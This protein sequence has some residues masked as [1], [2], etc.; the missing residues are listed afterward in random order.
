MAVEKYLNCGDAQLH[1]EVTLGFVYIRPPEY[2]ELYRYRLARSL[3][4]SKDKRTD[5][6][7]SSVGSSN[8]TLVWPS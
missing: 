1:H 8:A 3:E 5:L 4:P 2:V 6:E 7:A